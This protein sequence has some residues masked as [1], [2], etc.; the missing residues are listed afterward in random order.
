MIKAKKEKRKYQHLSEFCDDVTLMLDN[1]LKFNIKGDNV[2]EAASLFQREFQQLLLTNEYKYL[3]QA[4]TNKK[5]EAPS[6]VGNPQESGSTP[7][8]AKLEATKGH[9][10]QALFV[11]EN[12]EKDSNAMTDDDEEDDGSMRECIICDQVGD[13]LVCDNCPRCFHTICLGLEKEPEGDWIC[14]NCQGEASENLFSELDCHTKEPM[15]FLGFILDY[16]MKHDLSSPFRE[17]V[18]LTDKERHIYMQV[19]KKPMD[20]GMIQQAMK[21]P[22]HADAVDIISDIRLVWG[23]CKSFNEKESLLW[24]MANHLSNLFEK[25]FKR[26]LETCLNEDEKKRLGK[27]TMEQHQQVELVEK[28]QFK[29]EKTGT[30]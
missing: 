8:K 3:L 29:R 7:K 22:A 18:R 16:L 10:P 30:S 11:A 24:R 14:P 26:F 19:I 27:L 13:L 9:Q 23:N 25:F 5:R 17:A 4:S 1:A 15:R 2:Y 12:S 6:P 20:L 21:N 28:G